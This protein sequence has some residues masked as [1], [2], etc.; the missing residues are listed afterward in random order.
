MRAAGAAFE[1]HAC[2]ELQ[3]AGFTLLDRNYTTRHGE[4]DLVMLEGGTVVFVEVRQRRHASHGG[5]AASV[6]TSKQARI[7][8]AAELWLAAHPKYAQRPCR[9][10]VISYDGVG[11]DAHMSHWRSAFETH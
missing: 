2:A 11:A 10:D 3:R 7:I 4:L 1:Q 8:A 9:F 5:A 6:T